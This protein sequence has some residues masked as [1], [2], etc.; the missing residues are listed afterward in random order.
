MNDQ[1]NDQR[2]TTKDVQKQ[3]ELAEQELKQVEDKAA[4]IK[5][6]QRQTLKP[7]TSPKPSSTDLKKKITVLEAQIKNLTM[8]NASLRTKQD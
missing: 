3:M 6:Q 5:K 2:E 1:I 7:T 4:D 8:E